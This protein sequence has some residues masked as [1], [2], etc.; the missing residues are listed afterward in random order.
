VPFP[1]FY[2][3][4]CVPLCCKDTLFIHRDA[5]PRGYT[6]CADCKRQLYFRVEEDGEKAWHAHLGTAQCVSV[7]EEAS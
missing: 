5:L 2:F 6:Q 1:R 7:E 4:K 3:G